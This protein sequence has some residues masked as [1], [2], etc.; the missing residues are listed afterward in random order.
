MRKKLYLLI[1]QM[2]IRFGLGVLFLIL[3]VKPETGVWTAVWLS[4]G[5]LYYE[6][7]DLSD[8]MQKL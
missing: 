2:I 8:K 3:L 7:R 5:Y 1:I 6:I 4:V